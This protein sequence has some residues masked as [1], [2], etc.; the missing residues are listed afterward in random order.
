MSRFFN[1]QR[2]INHLRQLRKGV[3]LSDQ[4]D[5]SE[6]KK[7]VIIDPST[8][9]PGYSVKPVPVPGADNVK[10][11]LKPAPPAMTI[12][13]KSL[14]SVLT[15]MAV[16]F[17]FAALMTG[18]QIS[19]SNTKK[20]GDS[21]LT[22]AAWIDTQKARFENLEK[23]IGSMNAAQQA[24]W[25]ALEKKLGPLAQSADQNFAMIENL[26]QKQG[27]MRKAIDET[28]FTVQGLKEKYI[29]IN[30]DVKNLKDSQIINAAP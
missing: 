25:D 30:A 28:K 1:Q 9:I 27:E 29:S 21:A 20:V 22:A 16:V 11:D 17:G 13:R 3:P 15:M 26:S 12:H 10:G 23:S 6:D 2:E 8:G 18:I 14:H 19:S 7:P 5:S 24:R 4:V